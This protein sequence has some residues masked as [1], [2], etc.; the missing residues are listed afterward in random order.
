[1][2]RFDWSYVHK[3]TSTWL[4]LLATL[5]GGAAAAFVAAPHEWRDAFPGWMGVALLS[6]SMVTG[7]LVPV[8][9]SFKQRPFSPPQAPPEDSP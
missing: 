5:Q 7:A 8:A 3:R 6:G 4:S 1:M 9:T 2:S